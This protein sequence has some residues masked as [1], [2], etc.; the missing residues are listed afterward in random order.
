MR[1]AD[2]RRKF[3]EFFRDKEH[4]IVSSS[5]VVPHDDPTLMF[6]NAGMNQFKGVFT[7]QEKRPYERATTTQKCIRAGGKHNDLDAV[8]Y[9]ARHLTFFEMLGNF[10]FGNYFK[11]E[12]CAWAWDLVTNGFGLDP[13]RL[14]VTV[15]H[16]DDQA[17]AIWRDEVGV[18]ADRIV[19]LG[20]KDNYW[21]MG[22]VGPCGP[23]SEIF[24]D[25]GPAASCGPE[26]ALG[27]CDCDRWLE[28]W[29]LV[30]MQFEQRED[31]SKIELPSPSIDTGMGLERI[32]LILQGKQSV[33]ETDALAALIEEIARLTGCPAKPGEETPHRVIADHVRSLTFAIADGAYPSNEGR[34]YVLR[35]ILRRAARYAY[36]L[37]SQDPVIYQLVDFLGQEMGEAFPEIVERQDLIKKLIHSEEEQFGRT[38]KQGMN[39]FDAEVAELQG[40]QQK[41][42]PAQAAFFLHDTCGFPIDLTEQM[43]RELELTVDK[44][45][46]EELMG[47]QK[48]RSRVAT[49]ASTGADGSSGVVEG[50]FPATHFQGYHDLEGEGKVLWAGSAGDQVQLILDETCFYAEGGG[51]VGDTGWVSG[52]DYRLR[53]EDTR[54]QDGVFVHSCRL[55]DGD[56]A[57]VERGTRAQL[58][59]DAPRRLEIQRNH[60][61]THL[62]HAALREVLGDHVQQKGSL[63]APDRLRFDVSHF[64]KIEPSELQRVEELVQEHVLLDTEVVTGEYDKDEALARGAMAFFGEKYGDRVRVVEISDFSLELCGGAH[65]RRTGEIGGFMIVFEGSVSSGVRR[66]EALTGNAVHQRTRG[67]EDLLRELCTQLKTDRDGLGDRV[68]SLLQEVKDLKTQQKKAEQRDLLKDLDDGAGETTEVDGHEVVTASW[69]GADQDELLRVGDALKRRAGKRIFILLSHG[70]GS[71]QFIVGSSDEVKKGS[72]HCGNVA[73]D[74]AKVMGGGGGGKPDLARAGGKD[75]SKIPEAITSM[76]EAIRAQLGGS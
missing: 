17:R 53:V 28:F 74:G 3:L 19:G 20:E 49:T 16:E 58:Q 59:V 25:Q 39:R 1:A 43:A 68:G 67:A 41:E 10:S 31:G 63:V 12:A 29:N 71:V 69:E 22:D 15:F 9:T 30:F 6:A 54:K 37:G 32:A 46:F 57:A 44:P 47:Q 27:V 66:I 62:M 11:S 61:A 21:S 36:R 7:G 50:D 38:L 33:F 75:A 55:L 70:D 76:R 35:R 42:F 26:C 56:L 40:A 73:R 64:A 2:I 5:P 72:V 13:D 23:C 65:C 52:A 48:E 14:W 18:A 60:T 34:G 4:E 45:G 24:F 51:Q 8:G